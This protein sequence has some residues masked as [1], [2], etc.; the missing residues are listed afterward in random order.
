MANPVDL[1][2]RAGG[3]LFK[4]LQVMQ[5]EV[6]GLGDA[7]KKVH[8]GIQ[9]DLSHSAEG[10]RKFGANV[11]AASQLVVALAKSS[12]QGL[13]SL[14]RNLQEV[15]DLTEQAQSGLAA[16]DKTNLTNV[17]AALRS[18]AQTQ[19]IVVRSI[20]SEKRA[21]IEALV[22]AK[23]VTAE[24]GKLLMEV[25]EV[26]D[27][28]KEAVHA[29]SELPALIDDSVESTKTLAQQYREAVRE[30]QRIGQEFGK[31]SDEFLEATRNAAALKKEIADV[32]DRIR[33]LNPGDKLA[34]FSQFGNAIASGAQAVGGFFVTFSSG[35]QAIQETI[36]K[37]QS[38]LFAIQGAQGFIRDFK[39][40]F[41]NVRAVLGLTAEASE[42][43]AL[44]SE[45]D[46]IAKG[47]EAVATTAVGTASTGAAAGVRAFTAA[48]LANPLTAAVAILLAL[49][50]AMFLFASNT[51]QAVETYDDLLE[52]LQRPVKRRQLEGELEQAELLAKMEAERLKRI[53][54]F[55]AGRRASIERTSAE[56]AKDAE[57]QSAVDRKL[58]GSALDSVDVQRAAFQSLQDTKRRAIK[59]NER[60]GEK[61]VAD[62][63]AFST[64]RIKLGLDENA[65]LAEVEKA[66]YDKKAQFRE[67]ELQGEADLAAK[68]GE[69]ASK[70][71]D[72]LQE[73]LDKEKAAAELRLRIREQLAS[74]IEA[75]EKDLA[76]KIKALQ[77]DQAD[78]ME[79]VRL[80]KAASDE[81][82][83]VLER[84]LRREIALGE[85]R[86]KVGDEAFDKLT[87]RQKQA[88]ADAIIAAG[89]GQLAAQQ[90]EQL[91]TLRL[92]SEQ[93]YLKE[94]QDLNRANQETLL[95]IQAEGADRARA[96]LELDLV[97]RA[98]DL[99]KAGA[100]DAQITADATAKRAALNLKIAQ[101]SIDLEE[102]TQ[103]DLIAARTAGKD[104]NTA[105]ERAAQIEILSVRLEFA[106]KR[107]ALINDDGT[108]ESAALVASAKKTVAEL[109]AELESVKSQVVPFSLFDLLG[110]KLND[111]DKQKVEQ[112]LASIGQSILSIVN[113]NIAARQADLDNQQSINEQ[114]IS[115]NQNHL[116]ELEQQLKEE[117]DLQRQGLANNVDGVRAAI[118]EK[119]KIERDALAEKK[120]L[121]IEEAKLARQRAIAESAQQASSLLTAG[122]TLFQK[123]AF[124]GPVG[125]ITS[126]ATIASMIA[127]FIALK[128]KLSA[129]TA[130][131]FAKGTKS[132]QR[133]AGMATGID[134]VPAMLTE[135]EAVIP[136]A[137]NRK[138]RSLVGAIIDDDFSKLPPHV[139]QPLLDSINLSE[140]LRGTGV[141]VSE[142]AMRE[143]IQTQERSVASPA[144]DV[145]GL[146]AR[147]DR[148]TE[149]VVSL[150]KDAK[151]RPQTETLPNGT[152]I[153][154][155]P[156]ETHIIRP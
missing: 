147:I 153:I 31:N 28:M 43:A 74:N 118:N 155:R 64:L 117:E 57:R 76:E 103:L 56:L 109:T 46:S 106:K 58:R 41:E 2:F 121:L 82:V 141:K 73:Q 145:S 19:G 111:A 133:K 55:Q 146:E 81:E 23:K 16:T 120:R 114:L 125:I 67:A 78:P 130:Q 131:A 52:R 71:A 96:Q 92:L 90:Q 5:A 87:E 154:R 127:G 97:K 148:L 53:E 124:A 63:A 98:E 112:A 122:A 61:E 95:S 108:A 105:A 126:I 102:Q 75:I 14:A 21:R 135:D 9:E 22:E 79:Q 48:L 104:G 156:G 132:V 11:S 83:R 26:V 38:F 18:I 1:E 36:Y 27:T 91:N 86:A 151:N 100:T 110:F 84:N 62:A 6:N 4:D 7:H 94:V 37:F 39:D 54:D 99:R 50:G 60:T 136:V 93:A 113:S 15:S 149:E 88:S 134:T 116:Q 77:L 25:T 129:A 17:N 70:A 51:E 150:R 10:A 66:Y 8:Q 49:A 119:K 32:G 137:A 89:G 140:L 152:R 30:A 33:A 80:R 45:V 35:N 139:L 12:G 42:A 142:K 101:E 69:E 72:K 34:A 85:L 123:G 128:S 107:L 144:V 24:E 44:A 47:E 20:T 13:Q 115:D 59:E 68:R 3:S 40:A 143:D 65:K 138:H 29:T